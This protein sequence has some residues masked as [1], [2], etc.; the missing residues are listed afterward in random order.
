MPWCEGCNR[1]LS[2]P[3]VNPDGSCPK[4]GRPVDQV[5]DDQVAGTQP[6][7]GLNPR[8][9]WHFKVLVGAAGAYLAMRAVQGIA[10]A[11]QHIP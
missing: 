9:P 8:A 6:A 10:W 3:T 7:V 1:Y 5:A 4:C 2:S 11:L